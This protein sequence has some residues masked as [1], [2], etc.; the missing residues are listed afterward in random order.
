MNR[1]N[2]GPRWKNKKKYNFKKRNNNSNKKP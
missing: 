2:H 1:R